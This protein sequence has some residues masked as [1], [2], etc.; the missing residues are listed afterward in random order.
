MLERA[1][2]E[3]QY[4]LDLARSGQIW[5]SQTNSYMIT[6]MPILRDVGTRA[7]VPL[8]SIVALERDNRRQ[9]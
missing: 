3:I 2:I 6:R 1:S 9:Y 5:P 4:G 8:R 7:R